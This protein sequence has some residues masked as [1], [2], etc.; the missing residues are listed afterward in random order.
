[1][2]FASDLPYSAIKMASNQHFIMYTFI[3]FQ[4]SDKDPFAYIPIIKRFMRG[5]YILRPTVSRFRSVWN[6]HIVFDYVR[7]CQSVEH[8]N[9]KDLTFRLT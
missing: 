8:L 1:M 2:L 4:T 3:A 9:L 5:V 6:V 7:L